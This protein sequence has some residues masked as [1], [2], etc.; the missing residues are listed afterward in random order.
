MHL[1][2]FPEGWSCLPK[3]YQAHAPERRVHPEVVAPMGVVRQ[4]HLKV[5]YAGNGP[6]VG[7]LRF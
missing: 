4:L 3:L 6:S 2:Y 1:G 5:P 7:E